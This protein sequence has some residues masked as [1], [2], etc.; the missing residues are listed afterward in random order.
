VKLRYSK[1]HALLLSVVVILALLGI[2]AGVARMVSVAVG[3]LDYTA[4]LRVLPLARI[5][6]AAL[7]DRW[8]LGFP[9]LAML[10]VVPG[11][12]FLA[13]GPLQFSERIRN[14]HLSFHRWSGR[15]LLVTALCIGV[16]GLTLGAIFPF[17]GPIAQAAVFAAGGLFLV[18]LT[19][20]FH[21]IRRG[22]IELHREWMIRMFSL[23]LAIASVRLIALGLLALT[24]VTL[25]TAAAISFW[26][27]WIVT[28]AIAE[29]W[30][31]HTRPLRVDEVLAEESDIPGEMTV[32]G[33][34][35]VFG[36]NLVNKPS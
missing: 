24:T 11:V 5:Q 7:L 35:N 30:I 3:G 28:F 4:L 17:G 9:W 22:E 8:F 16:S 36:E 23:G 20:A 25:N 33:T 12:L 29:W 1:G 31:R 14:K 2:T 6:E 32:Q 10:H 21:S 27:G 18:S 34:A 13:M 15:V 19:R 26:G